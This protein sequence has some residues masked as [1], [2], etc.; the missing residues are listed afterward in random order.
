MYKYQNRKTALNL[1]GKVGTLSELFE[2]FMSGG[3]QGEVWGHL[4]REG[5]NNGLCAW[6]GCGAQCNLQQPYS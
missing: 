4:G 6:G 2:C 5:R 3:G 1:R